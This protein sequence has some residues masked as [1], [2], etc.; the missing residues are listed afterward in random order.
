[1]SARVRT[2]YTTYAPNPSISPHRIF[3]DGRLALH[4][5]SF[6]TAAVLKTTSP[7]RQA[8]R[9]PSLKARYNV[10]VQGCRTDSRTP[11]Q[12]CIV[13]VIGE[14]ICSC[15][16]SSLSLCLIDFG[17]ANCVPNLLM[18]KFIYTFVLNRFIILVV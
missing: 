11:I 14:H 9:Q 15:V 2:S 10:R 12:Y 7:P 1:M 13:G 3:L 4:F 5:R 17:V 6:P 8:K 16:S 18:R